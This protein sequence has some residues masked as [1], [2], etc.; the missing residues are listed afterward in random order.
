MGVRVGKFTNNTSGGTASYMLGYK[1]HIFNTSGI[2]TISQTNSFVD[3]LVVGGGGGSGGSFVGVRTGSEHPGSGGGGGG[4]SVF[5]R[6]WQSLSAGSYPVTVGSGGIVGN[7]FSSEATSGGNSIFN[8][9]GVNGYPQITSVGGGRGG[10]Q[11]PW[12]SPS[13]TS[14]PLLNSPEGSGGGASNTWANYS[15]TGNIGGLGKNQIGFG[16]SGGRSGN[17]SVFSS[18]TQ[19]ARGGAGGGAGGPVI[20]AA[21]ASTPLFETGGNGLPISPFVGTPD[22]F[23]GVG[24]GGG[25]NIGGTPGQFNPHIISTPDALSYGRG[26]TIGTT[27]GKFPATP[28][29]IIIKII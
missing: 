8:Q 22:C 11:T 2:L 7:L 16:F 18:N 19:R 23:A 13:G 6:K 15:S 17:T 10:Q 14:G 26:G 28:G 29:V 9:P 5:T 21:P 24:G 1:V 3:I 4:G 12:Q 25:F 20:T 27:S